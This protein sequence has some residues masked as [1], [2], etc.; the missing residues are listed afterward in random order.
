MS[1]SLLSGNGTQNI[2]LSDPNVIY[3]SLHRYDHGHF[4]PTGKEA[5]VNVVGNGKSAGRNINI[6]WSD[7]QM[8]DA[9]YIHAFTRILLPIAYEF[10]PEFVLGNMKRNLD[11]FQMSSFY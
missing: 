7:V 1:L 8:G 6:P 5:D 11:S 4:F 10:Q 3:F 2:F 9:E